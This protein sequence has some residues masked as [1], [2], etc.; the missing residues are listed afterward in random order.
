MTPLPQDLTACAF[1]LIVF[2]EMLE[3][4]NFD[5]IPLLREFH[6]LL[7]PGGLVCCPTPNLNRIHS[8]INFVRG[9]SH[10]N[11]ASDLI[12]NLQP[13]TGMAVGLHWREWTKQE[14][15][16]LFSVSGFTLMEHHYDQV[17]P[18]TLPFPRKQMIGAMYKL[19]P[20][21]CSHQVGVFRK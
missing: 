4:L 12:R 5:P 10:A 8:R 13:E 7:K 6:S 15:I 14:L 18:N 17:A 11:P 19:S 16:E 2:D 1:D 20:A 9:R 21:F 3:H